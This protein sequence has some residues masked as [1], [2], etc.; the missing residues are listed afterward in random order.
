MKG[1]IDDLKEKRLFGKDFIME[2]EFVRKGAVRQWEDAMS[3]E[4]IKQFDDWSAKKLK[5]FK[6]LKNEFL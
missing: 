5:N 3:K 1:V 2:G 6:D 4:L